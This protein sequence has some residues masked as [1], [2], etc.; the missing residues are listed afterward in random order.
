LKNPITP[1]RALAILAIAGALAFGV[2]MVKEWRFKTAARE[3]AAR[4]A[5]IESVVRYRV[6]ASYIV[7][8]T[9]EHIDFDYVAACAVFETHYRDGDRSID[10]PFG[11]AP[12]TFIAP[13]RDGHA[14]QVVTPKACDHQAETGNIP[15]DLI[16]LVIFYE[17]VK[18]LRFGWGYTSQDAFDNARA[19]IS[20]EGA[21]VTPATYAEYM[22][23]RAKA[24][25]EY[26]PFL[27]VDIP[28]G[29]SDEYG[30]HLDVA[31]H[32]NFY[33]RAPV[34]ADIRAA[35]T[36]E[37]EKRGRPEFWVF[38]D[39]R[40]SA[41]FLRE[42][43][44]HSAIVN[45]PQPRTKGG[46]IGNIQAYERQ[47]GAMRRW[48][49]CDAYPSNESYP[50]LPISLSSMPPPGPDATVFPAKIALSED[51]KGLAACGQINLAI[52]DRTRP[53]RFPV[54]VNDTMVGD[55]RFNI[56]PQLVFQRDEF[57]LTDESGPYEGI[58]P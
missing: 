18:N 17:D 50:Y 38:G 8:D 47:R 15:P 37:W 40:R 9:G 6:K 56:P 26:K 14:I 7:K 39:G 36:A 44:E 5:M 21:S 4:Q 2:W 54:M 27:K 42:F 20:F 10:T 41:E 49:R 11:V 30:L 22:A 16:P 12:H 3:A 23:W 31:S 57:T 28:W 35:V 46:G 43:R 55:I 48:N 32:C 51:W 13:T 34:V 45:Y 29:Y 33:V 25:A 24:V 52:S 1:A 19:R 53:I 58:H